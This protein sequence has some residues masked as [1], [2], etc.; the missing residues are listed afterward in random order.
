VKNAQNQTKKHKAERVFQK[1][2][3]E[4]KWRKPTYAITWTEAPT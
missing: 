4:E 3:K 1:C 2:A